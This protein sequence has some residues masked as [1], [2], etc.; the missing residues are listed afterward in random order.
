VIS[1]FSPALNAS[2]VSV[3]IRRRGWFLQME[4]ATSRDRE[5]AK[6]HFL[7]SINILQAWELFAR[8]TDRRGDTETLSL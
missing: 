7:R 5:Q 1:P 4:L 3:I 8:L 2:N 6:G